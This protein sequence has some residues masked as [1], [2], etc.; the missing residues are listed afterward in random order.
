MGCAALDVSPE[1]FEKISVAVQLKQKGEQM[2]VVKINL[3]GSPRPLSRQSEP[4]S[5]ARFTLAAALITAA[6]TIGGAEVT[7]MNLDATVRMLILDTAVVAAIVG[8]WATVSS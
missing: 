3:L 4:L 7:G 1:R 6:I 5:P 2:V 8:L